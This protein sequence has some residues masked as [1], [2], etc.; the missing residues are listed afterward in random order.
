V[1][2]RVATTSPPSPQPAVVGAVD[3]DDFPTAV[4]RAVA[5]DRKVAVRAAGHGLYA[6]LGDTVLISTTRMDTVQVDLHTRTA[7]VGAG[8]P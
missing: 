8:V 7:R 2:S 5:H 1:A 4:R 3:T 6:D